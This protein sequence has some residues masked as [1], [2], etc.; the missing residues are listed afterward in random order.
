[1]GTDITSV[2]EVRGSDGTWTAAGDIF[3]LDPEDHEIWGRTHDHAPFYWRSYGMFGFLAGVRVPVAKPLARDRG[4]PDGVTKLAWD[5]IAGTCYE[6]SW[7]SLRELLEADYEQTIAYPD[8]EIPVR[9]VLGDLYF[10]HLKILE[11]LGGPDD[12]RVV[13][14]FDS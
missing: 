12:V 10:E 2:A 14:G 1:M 11:S 7:V 8:E 4:F 9:E 5:E 6:A 3:P 13:F